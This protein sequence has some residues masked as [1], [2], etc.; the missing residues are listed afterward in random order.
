[1]QG[2]ANTLGQ[3]VRF[4]RYTPGTLADAIATDAELLT[5]LLAPP[6]IWLVGGED[7][8]FSQVG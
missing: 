4:T 3:Q 6:K 2:A 8:L 7:Q 5:R 1:M